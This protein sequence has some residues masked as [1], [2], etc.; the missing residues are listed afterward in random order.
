VTTVE[1]ETPQTSVS[2][3]WE[4][5]PRVAAEGE[6]VS[7]EELQLAAR[8]HGMQLEALRYDITPLGMHYLLIHFDVP[9]VDE[10]TFR[11][12]V[13]GLVRSPLTL[14]LDE[15]RSRP[16][17]TLPVTLEC[18]GNGRAR[19]TP[20]PISQPWLNE[21]VGTA[22]WTGT[23]LLPILEEA[24][25]D[26]GAVEVVFTGHDRGVQGGIEQD[27]E[28]SL[29]VKE[30]MRPEV[31]LA[32]EINGQPLPPQHGFPLRVIVPGWYGMT[33]VKWL[34]RI[35]LVGQPFGGYQKVE[36]YRVTD[37]EDEPGTQVTRILPRSL[38]LPPGIPDFVTRVRLLPPGP[39]M[40]E[41]R[42]WS[43]TGPVERVEVTTDGGSSWADADL[44][45][46]VSPHAWR[47]WTFPWAPTEPGEYELAS[48]AT[49]AAGNTQPLEQSW[50]LKGHRNNLV[51]RVRVLVRPGVRL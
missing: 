1:P 28:F 47:R 3:P 32:Y 11:L 51:Q 46:P 26:D 42:S 5:V 16:R 35:T 15:L 31:L 50:N 38:M 49:D 23:P 34:K 12:D 41:G 48:R 30:A 44:H 37:R 9:H 33:H 43:G 39:T 24:G 22:E 21:A 4:D 13:R 14:T 25:A 7:L 18:S 2:G 17:V 20:R 40:L 6:G 27:Y 8:N 45:A 10:G 29:P 36:A 19:L